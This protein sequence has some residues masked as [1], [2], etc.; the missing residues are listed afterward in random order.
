GITMP[1]DWWEGTM[2]R[3]F[4]PAV[5]PAIHHIARVH[6]E[7]PGDVGHIQPCPRRQA[8]LQTRYVRLRQERQEIG[9]G[10]R[11][12]AKLVLRRLDWR[13]VRQA[14][15]K[16]TFGKRGIERICRHLE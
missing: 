13:I 11:G 2:W 4:K 8:H 15:R 3:G 6:G 12:D 16:L 7:R 5:G 14:E 10:V 1:S 9:I